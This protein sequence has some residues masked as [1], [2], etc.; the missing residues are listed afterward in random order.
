MWLAE[1][2]ILESGSAENLCRT[3]VHIKVHKEHGIEGYITIQ[4]NLNAIGHPTSTAEI[5][6]LNKAAEKKAR[7]TN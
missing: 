7:T 6:E 2:E 4:K 1:G 3:Q 5:K